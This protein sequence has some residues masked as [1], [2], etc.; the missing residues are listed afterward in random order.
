MAERCMLCNEEIKKIFLDKLN[1]TIIKTGNKEKS[2]KNYVCSSCQK[3]YKNDL[4]EKIS[5]IDK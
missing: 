5:E 2:K 3:E 1:G 4:K